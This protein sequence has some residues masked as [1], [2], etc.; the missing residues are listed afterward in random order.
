MEE[1]IEAS[2]LRIA[3]FGEHLVLALSVELRLIGKLRHSAMR[4]SPFRN[5]PGR[6]DRI[7][8]F[9]CAPLLPSA[10]EEGDD[11]ASQRG[12]ETLEG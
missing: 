6:L 4:F 12:H 7:C 2:Q 10:S 8:S 5:A 1:G 11:V 3:A 9:S